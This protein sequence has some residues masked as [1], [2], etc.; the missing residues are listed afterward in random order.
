MATSQKY[1][2]TS[3]QLN[4]F[5]PDTKEAEPLKRGDTIDLDPTS[6]DARRWLE[7]NCI[8]LVPDQAATADADGSADA[9]AGGDGGS[10][11]GGDGGQHSA[12]DPATTTATGK[13]GKSVAGS[14]PSPATA[15][16]SGQGAPVS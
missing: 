14:T 3:E 12:P 4:R 15:A 13:A 16:D 2:V 8:L 10:S 7:G 11:D 9:D 1:I 6:S 5:N